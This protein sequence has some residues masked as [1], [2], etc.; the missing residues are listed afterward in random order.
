MEAYIY[1][2]RN[3]EINK[4]YIGSRSKHKDWKLLES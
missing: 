1:S 4:T 3:I 2:Y